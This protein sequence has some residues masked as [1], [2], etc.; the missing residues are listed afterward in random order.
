MTQLSFNE[1]FRKRTKELAIKIINFYSTLSK[2]NEQ[3]VI[4]KQLLRS[5]TSTASNFRAVSRAR[6][7]K[8]RYAKLSIVVEESDETLFWLELLEESALKTIPEEIKTEALEITKVMASYRK[9]L[10]KQ[11]SSRQ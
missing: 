5:V 6:S 11:T 2:T 7:L 4:G 3:Q 9:T 8:E 1:S 10:K